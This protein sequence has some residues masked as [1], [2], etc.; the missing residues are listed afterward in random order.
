MPEEDSHL[1]DHARSQ[2]HQGR[3]SARALGS[4]ALAAL[5]R[6]W[7]AGMRL[8]VTVALL[9]IVGS[10]IDAEIVALDV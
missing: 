1:P 7:I 3:A 10:K 5:S 6:G 9:R 8:P 4:H 2:A